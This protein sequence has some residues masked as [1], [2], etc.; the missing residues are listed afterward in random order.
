MRPGPAAG[1]PTPRC[2]GATTMADKTPREGSLDAPRRHPLEWRTDAFYDDAAPA[3]MSWSGY[4]TSATA[5]AGASASA[6][7]F[8]RCSMPLTPRTL[9]NSKA[10]R[11]R[12]SG[13]SWTTA[14]CAT[15]ASC[16]SALTCPLT[17]GTSTFPHL[18]L[19]AKAKRFRDEGAP[20]RDKLLSDTDT[21]GSLAGIPVV[22]EVVN[23]VNATTAGTCGAGNHARRRSRCADSALPE[24]FCAEQARS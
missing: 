7:R 17:P 9:A 14:I 3:I 6:M 18:M 19:R 24:P 8:P 2:R 5:V 1:S 16:R 10:C 20:W 13:R 12:F 21:V 11:R 22:A 4:S 23:A 15:C